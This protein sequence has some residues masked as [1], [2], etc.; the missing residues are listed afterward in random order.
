MRE[1]CFCGRSGEVEDREPV[2][3]GDGE[4]GLEC[5][6][7]GRLDRLHWLPEGG[8]RQTLREAARRSHER[9]RASSP[10]DLSAARG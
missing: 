8:R 5:P 6:D 7:C 1:V 10:R 4:W 2:Y 3:L 9:A